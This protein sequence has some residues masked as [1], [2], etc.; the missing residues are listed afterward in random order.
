MKCQKEEKSERMSVEGSEGQCERKMNKPKWTWKNTNKE[1][2]E[3]IRQNR[4]FEYSA[5]PDHTRHSRSYPIWWQ[6]KMFK[7]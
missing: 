3:R 6:Y 5:Q 4:G 1:K 7:N 2:Q